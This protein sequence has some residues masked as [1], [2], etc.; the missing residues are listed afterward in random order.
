MEVKRSGWESGKRGA[1]AGCL[2]CECTA[3]PLGAS[4]VKGSVE[5][6]RNATEKGRFH[7]AA[8]KL[9]FLSP[10]GTRREPAHPQGS[11]ISEG[12]AKAGQGS[13][14]GDVGVSFSAGQAKPE[15]V[16]A[17]QSCSQCGKG[18]LAPCSCAGSQ[19]LIQPDNPDHE[20]RR[21]SRVPGRVRAAHLSTHLPTVPTHLHP[22]PSLPAQAT[23]VYGPISPKHSSDLQQ[24]ATQT[25][26]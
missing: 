9:P 26:A 1:L 13:S 11:L 10:K 15:A 22:V 18:G 3:E 6:A 23:T 2:G 20:G 17:Q 4:S 8:G 19:D 21:A 16:W 25:S 24:F 14:L 12:G 7:H 5:R